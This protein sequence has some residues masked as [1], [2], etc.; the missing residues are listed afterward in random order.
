MMEPMPA[1][2]VRIEANSSKVGHSLAGVVP[3]ERS[4]VSAPSR[5]GP[6][7]GGRVS[8]GITD[9][10]NGREMIRCS[11]AYTRH[12]LRQPSDSARNALSGQHT[13]EAKPPNSV[14]LVIGVRAS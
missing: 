4:D 13:V 11:A 8:D 7:D 5:A 14:R 3:A 9:I 1:E 10:C 12:A 6:L 2:I